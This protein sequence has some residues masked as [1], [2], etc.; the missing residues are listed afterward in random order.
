MVCYTTAY[1]WHLHREY[2]VPSR[3][4]LW[5]FKLAMRLKLQKDRRKAV[6]ARID[7]IL[8]V[9]TSLLIVEGGK[10]LMLAEP[11]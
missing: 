7:S 11:G 9:S 10:G 4:E 1:L 6:V 2:S 3:Q 5:P 8:L